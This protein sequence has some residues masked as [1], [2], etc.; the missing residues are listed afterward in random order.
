MADTSTIFKG[1]SAYSADFS[2][3]VER[4]VGIAGL[5]IRLLTTQKA[6]ISDQKTQLEAVQANFS[7]LQNAVNGIADALDGS[8]FITSVS[9]SAVASASVSPGVGEGNYSLKVSDVGAYATAMTSHAWVADSTA[10]TFKLTVGASE[11]SLTPTDNSASAVALAIN[12]RYGDQVRASVLNVGSLTSPDYRL[13]LQATRLGNTPVGLK[14]D[15]VAVPAEQTVGRLAAYEVNGSGKTVTST[16]RTAEIA[17]GLTVSML[18][19]SDTAVDITVTRSTS[20]LSTA[21]TAFTDAFNAARDAVDGQRGQSAGSLQG[22]SLIRELSGV[23]SSLSTYGDANASVKGLSELGLE[24]DKT[25]HLTFSPFA[26]MAADMLNSNG[27]TAFLGSKAGGGFLKLAGDSMKSL[28]DSTTGSIPLAIAD[29]AL[30]ITTAETTIAD[31]QAEVD[32]LQERLIAQMAAA[33]ALVATMQNQYSYF[34]SMLAAMT[35]AN[36]SYN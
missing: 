25:G 16:T 5:P 12:Q 28:E 23:L 35:A 20:A 11:Y 31:K 8:S 24:L 4:A 19:S 9:D 29:M 15:D 21:L 10:H 30:R 6:G 14:K 33:D 36:Q 32:R 17:T 13:S 27:I 26:L 2:Q 7:A 22:Q 34:S 3:V 1:T 18:S